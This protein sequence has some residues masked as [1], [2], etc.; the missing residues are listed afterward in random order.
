[1]SWRESAIKAVLEY[2]FCGLWDSLALLESGK[3]KDGKVM[4][5]RISKRRLELEKFEDDLLLEEALYA[6][7][8]RGYEQ[9]QFDESYSNSMGY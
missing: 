8:R 4:R 3:G 5:E 6:S 7:R 9:G 1:M 2:E